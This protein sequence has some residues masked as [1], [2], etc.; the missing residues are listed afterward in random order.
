MLADPHLAD[1][2]ATGGPVNP[3]CRRC[4]VPY[5]A[6]ATFFEVAGCCDRCNHHGTPVV[7]PI[8]ALV[9]T[10]AVATTATR[11]PRFY[12]CSECGKLGHNA[13]RHKRQKR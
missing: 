12:N 9:A 11:R 2:P 13:R 7:R 10:T 3:E 1:P 5:M 4:G 6:C 8:T